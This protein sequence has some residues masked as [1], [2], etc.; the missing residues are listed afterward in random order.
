M[1][2][3][4]GTFLGHLIFLCLSIVLFSVN[5]A[6]G[7]DFWVFFSYIFTMFETWMIVTWYGMVD[8]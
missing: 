1:K 7:D 2:E 8:W 5:L 6:Q 3:Y 4:K